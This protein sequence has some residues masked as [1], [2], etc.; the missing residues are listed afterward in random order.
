MQSRKYAENQKAPYPFFGWPGPS[1][2]KFWL[3]IS[4]FPAALVNF[5]GAYGRGLIGNARLAAR[6]QMTGNSLRCRQDSEYMSIPILKYKYPNL[7]QFSVPHLVMRKAL[8]IFRNW[9]CG[10]KCEENFWSCNCAGQRS[11]RGAKNR[12]EFFPYPLPFPVA[13]WSDSHIMPDTPPEKSC[14]KLIWMLPPVPKLGAYAPEILISLRVSPR[15][16]T[17][18]SHPP[19]LWKVF[20]PDSNSLSRSQTWATVSVLVWLSGFPIPIRDELRS[21]RLSRAQIESYT[22]PYMATNYIALCPHLQSDGSG[23]FRF[24]RVPK[25]VRTAIGYCST[26]YPHLGS[27]KGCLGT[28]A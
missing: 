12:E 17:R 4:E 14:S 27:T 10:K 28:Q 11:S 22:H 8:E 9:K 13:F 20:P 6:P 19:S 24:R 1:L 5:Y 26:V 16:T 7:N 21:R 18:E 15:H 25:C 3:W 2:T 23:W